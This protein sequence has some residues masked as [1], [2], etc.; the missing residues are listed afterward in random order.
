MNQGAILLYSKSMKNMRPNEEEKS[1]GINSSE[2]SIYLFFKTEK[3][4]KKKY[5]NSK[6]LSHPNMDFWIVEWKNKHELW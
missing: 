3:K 1:V 4:S 2:N 6:E 5:V